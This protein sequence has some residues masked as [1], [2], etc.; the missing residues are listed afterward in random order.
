M[1]KTIFFILLP[2]LFYTEAINCQNLKEKQIVGDYIKTYNKERNKSY[3]LYGRAIKLDFK[4]LTDYKAL[5]DIGHL[6]DIESLD[7]CG[8][9]FDSLPQNFYNL[10]KLDHLVLCNNRFKHI[11]SCIKGMKNLSLLDLTLNVGLKLTNSDFVNLKQIR[12][13]RLS[14]C[15][16]LKLPDSLGLLS[17]L[18]DLELYGNK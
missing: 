13:L 5:E 16:I 2:L 3:A 17:N 1:T 7:L 9:F 12:F 6:L 8:N 11:P 18:D 10:E 15:D 14:R 4:K